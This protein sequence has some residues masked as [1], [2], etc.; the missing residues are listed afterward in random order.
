M[1][2]RLS[3]LFMRLPKHSHMYR[4]LATAKHAAYSDQQQFVKVM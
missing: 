3:S 1:I 2:A 4:P